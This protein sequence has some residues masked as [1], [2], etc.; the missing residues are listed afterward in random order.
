MLALHHLALAHG[1]ES[2]A[3][4]PAPFDV[5]PHYE[6]LPCLDQTTKPVDFPHSPD[7]MVTFD[8]GSISR[9]A[10]LGVSVDYEAVRAEAG[11]HAI[12]GRPHL[13]RILVATGAVPSVGRAFELYL[14]DRAPAWVPMHGVTLADAVGLIHAAGGIAVW[15]HP[16]ADDLDRHLDAFVEV[17][18]DGVDGTRSRA[19]GGE[20]ERALAAPRRRGLVPT[21]GSDWHGTWHGRLGDF[22]VRGEQVPEFVDLLDA[23]IPAT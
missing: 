20:V 7:V 16:S 10:E 8:C 5:A 15:A 11:E 6:F 4:W 19:T 12:L 14:S 17:G 13:A 23:R 21:G 3:S 9:L 1:K 22:T 18:R 2:V